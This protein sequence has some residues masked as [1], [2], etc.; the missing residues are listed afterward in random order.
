MVLQTAAT[1]A[2]G[3]LSMGIDVGGPALEVAQR[4]FRS[5]LSNRMAQL[6][7]WSVG[8]DR[9][10]IQL[11]DDLVDHLV[12]RERAEADD[13]VIGVA[14]PSWFGAVERHLLADAIDPTRMRTLVACST[15]LAAAVGTSLA[16]PAPFAAELVLAIDLDLGCSA[17]VVEIAP[18]V[19]RERA[20]VGL[21][22]RQLRA[23]N[24]GAGI[25]PGTRQRARA[26]AALAEEVGRAALGDVTRVVVVGD[27]PVDAVRAMLAE[28]HPPWAS[29]AIAVTRSRAAVARGAAFVADPDAIAEA[30][31][32]V[33]QVSSC[34]GRA[35]GV[36]T[37]DPDGPDTTG[38]DTTGPDTTGPDTT[39]PDT[40]ERVAAQIH[41]VIERGVSLPVV[42]DQPFDLGPDD[43]FDVYLDLY[44]QLP[45]G[46]TTSPSDHR[47]VATARHR[48][49]TRR[50]SQVTVVFSVGRDG[51]V[52]I[53]PEDEWIVDWRHADVGVHRVTRAHVEAASG[54]GPARDRRSLLGGGVV[55]PLLPVGPASADTDAPDEQVT[56][57]EAGSGGDAREAIDA[58][59]AEVVAADEVA[60]AVAP[61]PPPAR[62]PTVRPHEDRVPE[63]LPPTPAVVAALQR[64]ERLLSHEVGRMVALRSV[65]ALL[66]C[67]DGAAP[68][69]LLAAADRLEVALADRD[70][71]VADALRE[72]VQAVRD[73]TRRG[74]DGWY[75]GG[76]AGDVRDELGRVVEHLMVVVGFVSAA[77]Q[78]QLVLDA[79][80]LGLAPGEARAVVRSLVAAAQ[81]DRLEA[82][83]GD[84][85]ERSRTV[86]LHPRLGRFVLDDPP[87]PRAVSDGSLPGPSMR[88]LLD[89]R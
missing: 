22:L 54:H 79:M 88:V 37:V 82:V 56:P 59:A 50:A 40:D 29:A 84:L 9:P 49:E 18:G 5:L 32:G 39:G 23:E 34:L 64:C 42:R 87:L 89:L 3:V 38:P 35:L 81:T 8:G 7:H 76:S 57:P 55:R 11:A 1:T 53:G 77:E 28:A 21:S 85:D 43:G 15:P 48:H 27:D 80:L 12:R 46:A 78:R 41:A 75:F 86:R 16:A 25:V 63:P 61:I 73:E 68:G 17:S 72:A 31:D 33:W 69:E 67:A 10:E 2:T 83:T 44:E 4:G 58:S 14:A 24:A 52:S 65:F 6:G 66:G 20:T 60:V 62:V 74:G 71:D 36:L 45:L 51:R 26:L 70:D 47:V 19:V 30:P 13:V